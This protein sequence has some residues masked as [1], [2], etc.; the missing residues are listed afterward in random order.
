[1]AGEGKLTIEAYEDDEG[2]SPIEDFLKS[3]S[4]KDFSYIV[5]KRAYFHGYSIPQ[6][7]NSRHLE[8]IRS[9][10]AFWE[11]KFHSPTPYRTV[12]IIRGNKV[13]ILDMFKGSG[14]DG[15]VIRHI[16]KCLQRAHDWDGKRH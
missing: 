1:M 7:K 15:E 12:C 5:K 2:N 10:V 4:A 6:L 16:P 3:L 11:L 9:A 13:V 14:S 8:N